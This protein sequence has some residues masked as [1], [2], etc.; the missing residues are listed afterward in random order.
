MLTP[1]FLEAMNGTLF[2]LV[3]F[4]ATLF[5]VFI[6]G[7]IVKNGFRRSTLRYSISIFVFLVG[8][9]IIRGWV[10]WWRHLQ[11]I[12]ADVRWMDGHPMLSIGAFTQILGVICI[13]RV[14]APDGFGSYAWVGSALLAAGVVLGF[15]YI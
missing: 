14:F 5:A 13:I 12:G 7:E 6:V 3:L 4:A 2:V 11:N 8:E 9:G 10:W 15:V 1:K